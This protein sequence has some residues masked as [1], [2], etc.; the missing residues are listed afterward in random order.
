MNRGQSLQRHRTA[1]RHAGAKVPGAHP[2]TG[3]SQ[4]RQELFPAAASHD[5]RQPVSAIGLITDLLHER[6]TDQLRGLTHR[7]TWAVVSMESLLKGLLDLSWLDPAPS[8]STA[9]KCACNRC[10]TWIASHET[11][12]AQHKGLHLRVCPTQ[13]TAWTDP[14]LLEQIL[15]NLVGNAAPHRTRRHPGAQ[16]ARR[17]PA[18][19]G[20][21]HRFRHSHPDQAR[22]SKNLRSWRRP[23]RRANAAWAWV[24][25]RQTRHPIAAAP[26]AGRLQTGPRILLQCLGTHLQ[27]QRAIQTSAPTARPSAIDRHQPWVGMQV[28]IVEDDQ[29]SSRCPDQH[30]VVMGACVTAGCGFELVTPAKATALGSGHFRPP[31]GRRYRPRGHQTP[32]S[33]AS[34][35]SCRHRDRRHLARAIAHALAQS[36]LPVLHKPFRA[37]NYGP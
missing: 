1:Q 10:S 2:G 33:I 35:P 21:G 7:L 23:L 6:L 11:E 17:P 9:R 16:A 4:R 37:E 25:H 28:L 3:R 13:A 30:L 31:P 12:S 18:D 20:L 14:I 27:A 26:R 8:K 22:I 19:S 24:G 34:R 32:A 5:L 29:L 15:R 36:G